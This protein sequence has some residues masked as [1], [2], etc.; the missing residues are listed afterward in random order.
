MDIHNLSPSIGYLVVSNVPLQIV[1][2]RTS[3]CVYVHTHPIISLG[4]T[5][6]SE[7]KAHSD[8]YG[9][10]TFRK[11]APNFTPTICV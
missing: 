4:Y 3:P 9:Q 6:E 7:S 10:I 8:A 11:S 5:S 1:K 2:R